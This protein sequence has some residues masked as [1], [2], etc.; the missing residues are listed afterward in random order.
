[1]VGRCGEAGQF[2]SSWILLG[3]SPG[4]DPVPPEKSLLK[5]P[6]RC[7]GQGDP[8]LAGH[9]HP[10]SRGRASLEEGLGS[11]H[12][13]PPSPSPETESTAEIDKDT[14]PQD[15]LWEAHPEPVLSSQIWILP[16]G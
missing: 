3:L 5:L 8:P 12:T 9:G 1:M 13:A 6:G 10:G 15:T 14:N 7:W 4:R 11:E 2:T 16:G